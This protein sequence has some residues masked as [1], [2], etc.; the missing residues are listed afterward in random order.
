MF[1]VIDN[2][3]RT[4]CDQRSGSYTSL[5]IVLFSLC[6]CHQIWHDLTTLWWRTTRHTRM[7]LGL[8]II[9]Y[10]WWD[11]Y[12]RFHL[13]C[14]CRRIGLAISCF[15]VLHFSAPLGTVGAIACWRCRFE[16]SP[17]SP[18]PSMEPYTSSGSFILMDRN[19]YTTRWSIPL[20]PVLSGDIADLAWRNIATMYATEVSQWLYRVRMP[21][22][23]SFWG[24]ST[25]VLT[26]DG[27]PWLP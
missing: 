19:S 1:I 27:S 8:A 20:T 2:H 13:H 26:C 9:E 14:G 18:N 21:W 10:C 5:R 22:L 4:H 11:A 15:H 3:W 24:H 7:Q 23:N 16:R 12:T 25:V 6:L 17:S